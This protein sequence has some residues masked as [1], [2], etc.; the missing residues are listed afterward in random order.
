MG[1][2]A[3]KA[4]SPIVWGPWSAYL[5]NYGQNVRLAQDQQIFAGQLELGAGILG[6]DHAVAFLQFHRGALAAV[7]QPARPNRLDAPFLGL[8][9][10]RIRQINPAA[11]HFFA[12]D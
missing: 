9:L 3:L 5:T 10:G 2:P 12:L 8:L 4:L 11:G 6:K 7:E 1:E